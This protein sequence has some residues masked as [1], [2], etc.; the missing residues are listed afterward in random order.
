MAKNRIVS[1]NRKRVAKKV[2]EDIQNG[3]KVNITQAMREVGYK[4]ST[5]K[6]KTTDVVRSR[7]FQEETQSFLDQL[8]EQIQRSM[9]DMIK[10]QTK[11]SWRDNAEAIDKFKKLSSA[12]KG[13]NLE[14]NAI[15][16]TLI[17]KELD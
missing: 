1:L 15:E 6:A 4:E 8:E 13:N 14:G 7:E 17:N 16:I 2:I 12:M 9:K 11:A 10:K 3:K 5:A